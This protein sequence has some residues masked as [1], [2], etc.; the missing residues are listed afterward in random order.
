MCGPLQWLSGLEFNKKII[1]VSEENE[2][3]VP[4]WTEQ[5]LFVFNNL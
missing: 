1:L 2:I 5:Y 4:T 3:E